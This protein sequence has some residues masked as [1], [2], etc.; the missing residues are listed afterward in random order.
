MEEPTDPQVL[1]RPAVEGTKS[2]LEA[3]KKAGVRR[4]CMT[5][6]CVAIYEVNDADVPDVFDESHWTN[7]DKPRLG[8]YEKSKTLAEMAAWSYIE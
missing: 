3:C 7:V 5:S 1:I 6:S 8:A 4:V 2:V